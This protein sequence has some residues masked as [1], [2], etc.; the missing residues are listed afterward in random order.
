MKRTVLFLLT[1]AA[2]SRSP[3]LAPRVDELQQKLDAA[4]A[5]QKTLQ[6]EIDR[7]RRQAADTDLNLAT[8][9]K[10]V[11]RVANSVAQIETAARAQPAP[12]PAA[13]LASETTPQPADESAPTIPTGKLLPSKSP[14]VSVYTAPDS[15]L[16]DF[17]ETP[18]TDNP[19]LFPIRITHVA[20]RQYVAATHPSTQIVESE[21]A[22]KDDYGRLVPM[23]KAV[24]TEVEEMALEVGFSAQNLTRTEKTISYT[25]GAGTRIVVLKPG[26]TLDGLTVRSAFGSDLH[27]QAGGALRRFPVKY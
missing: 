6:A 10:T 2:C 3:D 4:R 12:Q 16:A 5:E 17:I 24:E 25:A 27:V 19:D 20:G 23:R 1:L 8:L 21:I 11:A 9:E 13:A 15:R 14:I 18:A 22:A 7:L 26:E